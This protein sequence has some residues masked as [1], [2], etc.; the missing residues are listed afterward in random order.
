M[1]KINVFNERNENLLLVQWKAVSWNFKDYKINPIELYS[2]KFLGP[3]ENYPAFLR[4]NRARLQV[5]SRRAG[6]RK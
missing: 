2:I 4:N 3:S 6:Q 1:F 5:V